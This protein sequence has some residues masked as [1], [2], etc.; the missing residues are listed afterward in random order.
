MGALALPVLDGR[1]EKTVVPEVE[2]A[3]YDWVVVNT[4]A[5]KDSQTILRKVCRQAEA[6]GVLDRVVAVTADLEESEWPGTIELAREQVAHYGV[7]FEVVRRKQGSILQ[8]VLDRHRKLVADGKTAPPWMSPANRY[9]TSHHKTDQVAQL[10]TRLVN[11]AHVSPWPSSKQRWC[12][13]DHKRD[14]VAPLLTRLTEEAHSTGQANYHDNPVRILNCLGM[15]A[16]ESSARSKL[17]PF[18]FDKRASN[19]KRHVDRWLP[20]HHWTAEE[21]WADIKASGVRWHWA[22][23]LGM[24]RLS[25]VF[26]IFAPKA[27]LMLA[28]KH[29]RALLDR[30]CEIEAEVGSKFKADLSLTEV[31]NALDRGEEPGEIRT[32]RM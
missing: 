29:N 4:S 21:V 7:R 22:Y 15:R 17:K 30:Y 25:C 2:L 26:C 28:G 13:S 11:E 14:Q 9:C 19:G 6:E 10:F 3:K 8:H 32:W 24:P 27:A 31:R 1:P 16:D 23:D 20:I 12:T 18:E 5:G